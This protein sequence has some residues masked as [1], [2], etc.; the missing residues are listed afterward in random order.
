MGNKTI[1]QHYRFLYL[2]IYLPLFKAGGKAK[3]YQ[4]L[5]EITKVQCFIGR[6]N[7]DILRRLLIKCHTR[8]PFKRVMKELYEVG[9]QRGEL[10]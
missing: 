5:I 2:S 8:L 7:T 3:I 4:N 9:K 10:A 6:S 1:L